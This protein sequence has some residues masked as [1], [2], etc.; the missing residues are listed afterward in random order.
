MNLEIIINEHHGQLN[1]SELEIAAFVINNQ[2]KVQAM[3]IVEL[4]DACHTSKSSIHRLTKKLGFEG[5]S[6]FKYSMKSL[7]K[8]QEQR[9]NLL[10]LQIEDISATLKLLRQSEIKTIVDKLSKAERIFAFGTGWGQQNALQELS[11]NLMRVGKHVLV[12]PAKLELDFLMPTITN[13]DFILIVSLSGSVEDLQDNIRLFNMKNVPICSITGFHNNFLA[14][15]APH[16][17]YFQTTP[18]LTDEHSEAI[19]F[20]TLNVVCDALYREYLSVVEG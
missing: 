5:F 17:L 2:E 11:R 1:P 16:N 19:S 6:E 20:I 18:V 10:D 4:A 8:K 3:S 15:H 7:P 12:I 9:K 14:Q 13:K